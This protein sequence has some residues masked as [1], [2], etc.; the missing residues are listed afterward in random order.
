VERIET[1][2]PRDGAIAREVVTPFGFGSA[3]LVG[4]DRAIFAAS[5]VTGFFEVGGFFETGSP[6]GEGLFKARW[7]VA[8]SRNGSRFAELADFPVMRDHRPRE[9]PSFTGVAS[10]PRVLPMAVA[11]AELRD[12]APAST[13]AEAAQLHPKGASIPAAARLAKAQ[14][15]GDRPRLRMARFVL[16]R[17]RPSFDGGTDLRTLRPEESVP[18]DYRRDSL[19]EC[20]GTT[21]PQNR[22]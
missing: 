12:P 16:T 6:S 19:H 14:P 11:T 9:S 10:A 2:S 13:R 18:S 20:R 5:V 1:A 17:R 3:M 15:R 7:T 8:S 21:G 22:F 4:V